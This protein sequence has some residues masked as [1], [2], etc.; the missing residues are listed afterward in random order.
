MPSVSSIS[1]LLD[2]GC[3]H[4]E[5]GERSLVPFPSI[6]P[7]DAF[8]LLNPDGDLGGTQI[9]F[10]DYFRGQNL[11]VFYQFEFDKNERNEML[12]IFLFLLIILSIHLLNHV[13][14]SHLITTQ[15]GKAGSKPTVEELASALKSHD[16]FIYFG[17]GSG[18]A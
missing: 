8:Y 1:A 7:L 4:E 16:L 9:Q 3:N 13:F 10:E 14:F 6:D 5:L 11:E 15:Q 18:K 17:H 12:H 2:K